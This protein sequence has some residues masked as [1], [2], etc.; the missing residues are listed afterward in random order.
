VPYFYL[1][2]SST[3]YTSSFFKSPIIKLIIIPNAA[4]GEAESGNI[5]ASG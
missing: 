2:T 1:N 3:P 5:V 4:N